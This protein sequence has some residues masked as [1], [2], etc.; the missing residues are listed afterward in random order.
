MFARRA[1]PFGV[2]VCVWNSVLMFAFRDAQRIFP[3]IHVSFDV[4]NNSYVQFNLSFFFMLTWF[5]V[6]L[7]KTVEVIAWYGKLVYSICNRRG[8]I[9]WG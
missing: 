7:D 8:P 3:F 2:R 4:F 1:F 6:L 5:Q 9:G